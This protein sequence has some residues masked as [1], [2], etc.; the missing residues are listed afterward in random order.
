MA[1]KLGRVAFLSLAVLSE[2]TNFSDDACDGKMLLQVESELHITESAQISARPH[3]THGMDVASLVQSSTLKDGGLLAF[4]EEISK[5]V[6][7]IA[8]AIFLT[9]CLCLCYFGL[10]S[11]TLQHQSVKD[12]G[13]S[14]SWC[15]YLGVVYATIYASTDQ[16]VP[17]M[18]Q[19]EKDLATS[20]GLMTA[21]VQINWVVKALF[22]LLAGLSDRTGRRC[23]ALPC[24]MLLSATCFALRSSAD[25][26]PFLGGTYQDTQVAAILFGGVFLHG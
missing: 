25:F 7:S 4:V 18:P 11:K 20:Q 14:R 3:P 12:E 23:V 6:V 22:A 24:M 1:G 19:M 10:P 17:S 21:T 9:I 15:I 13:C 8:Y 26:W 2:A 16:F 5:Y